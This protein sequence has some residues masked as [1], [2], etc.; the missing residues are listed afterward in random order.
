[1]AATAAHVQWE[2]NATCIH[3][4]RRLALINGSL[5]AQGDSLK[6][7]EAGL[8]YTIALIE[9][10]KVVLDA[11]GELVLLQYANRSR[12]AASQGNSSEPG[13]SSPHTRP[14]RK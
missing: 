4:D 1:M 11:G 9:A 7:E 10:D 8:S 13:N 14:H 3:G 2:L 6:A 5:Y 12:V